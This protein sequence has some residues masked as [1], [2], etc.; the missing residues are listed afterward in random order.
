M[1]LHVK[2][3]ISMDPFNKYNLQDVG[4]PLAEVI[5]LLL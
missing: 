4:S 5:D 2:D 1:K 3:L